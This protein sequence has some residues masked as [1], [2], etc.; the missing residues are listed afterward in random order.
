MVLII[1]LLLFHRSV[2]VVLKPQNF[3]S[4]TTITATISDISG[5]R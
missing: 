3:D 2:I 4:Q 1:V 5:L